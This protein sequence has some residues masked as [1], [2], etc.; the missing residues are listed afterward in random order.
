MQLPGFVQEPAVQLI[1]DKC[2]TSLV[3]QFNVGDV[4]CMKLVLSKVLGLGIVV[5][6]SLLKFPQIVK[7]ISNGSAQGLSFESYV[8]ETAA[9]AIS[10]AY[11]YRQQNPFSTFGES[12]FLTIQDIIILLLILNYRK[13]PRLLFAA[14]LIIVTLSY[15]LSNAS[16]VNDTMIA[17]LQ[18]AAIPTGLVSKIPQIYTN[19]VNGSTGQ[20]SA[21]AVF[22]YM[23]GS[24][25]RIFTT[26][27]EVDD[28]I[29]L[30][31]FLLS[32]ALNAILTLQMIIYWHSDK[33]SPKK[34][35]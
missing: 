12:V 1:G 31:G 25:A 3:E 22:G 9:Y 11:N 19:Y 5:G 28:L 33:L 8:L 7:I 26:I 24:L 29:I 23:A 30:T 34:E 17:W 15:V 27:T 4:D 16:I 2:Y 14:G 13:S 35:E 20:L 18:V 10:V 21:L 32:T 6:G